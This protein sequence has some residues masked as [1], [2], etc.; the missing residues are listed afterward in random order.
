MRNISLSSFPLPSRRNGLNPSGN[1]KIRVNGSGY[2]SCFLSLLL[3]A[4]SS[5]SNVGNQSCPATLQ[6]LQRFSTLL[7]EKKCSIVW[8]HFS[9]EH[10]LCTSYYLYFYDPPHL[11]DDI[12]SVVIHSNNKP[13]MAQVIAIS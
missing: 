4:S 12:I 13:E 1:V 7:S 3:A 2:V 9:R 8:K 11:S 5:S 6:T 10:A